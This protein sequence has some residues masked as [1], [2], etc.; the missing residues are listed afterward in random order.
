MDNKKRES[1]DLDCTPKSGHGRKGGSPHTCH[2]L[3]KSSETKENSHEKTGSQ[4]RV[5]V[6]SSTSS[7][8][9]REAPCAS[10]P[11]AQLVQSCAGSLAQSIRA[12]RRGSFH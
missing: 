5:Q 11:R 12:A 8:E 7:H 3:L 2:I 6:R 9:R 4:S 10:L 1:N